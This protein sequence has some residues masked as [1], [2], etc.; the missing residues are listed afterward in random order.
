TRCDAEKG[1][2]AVPDYFAPACMA[3][4]T[5]DNGGATATGVTADEITIVQIMT[6]SSTTSLQQ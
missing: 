1:T 5:G 3:P 4:F 2:I 6:P